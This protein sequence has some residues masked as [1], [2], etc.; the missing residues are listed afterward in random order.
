M[1]RNP[2]PLEVT[3]LSSNDVAMLRLTIQCMSSL[4]I[5]TKTIMFNYYNY[6]KIINFIIQYKINYYGANSV[7]VLT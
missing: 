3:K 4:S 1:Q 5:D 6:N 7:T 2:A